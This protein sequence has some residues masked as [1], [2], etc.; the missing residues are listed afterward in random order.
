MS[1]YFQKAIRKNKL[2][3]CL[4]YLFNPKSQGNSLDIT[5]SNIIFKNG[6]F[7]MVFY[8]IILHQPAQQR[9][10]SIPRLIAEVLSRGLNADNICD[11]RVFHSPF[12]LTSCTSL[13]NRLEPLALV[14]RL[15]LG[16]R[17][18]RLCLPLP[19]TL[20]TIM[21]DLSFNGL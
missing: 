8:D 20:R 15:S 4:K 12:Q 5:S 1:I 3:F 19:R 13:N 16:T 6:I 11:E 9:V 18:G 17:V 7:E 10:I 14:P 21:Q 2:Y